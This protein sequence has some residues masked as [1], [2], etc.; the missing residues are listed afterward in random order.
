MAR[1]QKSLGNIP[2]DFIR[3]NLDKNFLSSGAQ[4]KDR[5]IVWERRQNCTTIFWE[6]KTVLPCSFGEKKKVNPRCVGEVQSS[7]RFP[8]SF[9]KK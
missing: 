7:A 2:E 8:L 9:T 6:E 3:I 4:G 1:R 5:F